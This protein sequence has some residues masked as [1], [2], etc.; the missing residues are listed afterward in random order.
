FPNYKFKFSH[1]VQNRVRKDG[2]PSYPASALRRDTEYH[3]RF[4]FRIPNNFV[5]SNSRY[6][7]NFLWL[8][9]S[10]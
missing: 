10:K 5:G 3:C 7:M 2:P 4:G 1:A 6:R 8:E 9:F